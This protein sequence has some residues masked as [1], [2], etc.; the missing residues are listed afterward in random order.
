M[1]E[2]PT[3]S[4]M[5]VIYRRRAVRSYTRQAVDEVT[6]RSL[7]RA[8]CQAPTAMH[9]E[10]WAFVVVQDRERLQRY[11]DLAKE[12]ALQARDHNRLLDVPGGHALRDQLASPAFNVFYDASTLVVVCARPS[13]PFAEADC[14][15]AAENLMLA[16]CGLGLGTCCVGLA[17]PVLNRPEVKAELRIPAEVTAV[18]PIIVGIAAQAP[19]PVSR[20]E[21]V[22]LS[23]T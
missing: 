18:A 9:A 13:G 7:L 16:A 22:I 21:P 19:P 2:R 8:A 17:V 4:V 6:V 1:P 12:H 10:P 20:K 23:W 14:W 15:L 5:E 11:S 3:P